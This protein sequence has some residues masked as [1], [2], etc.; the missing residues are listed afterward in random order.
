M[1]EFEDESKGIELGGLINNVTFNGGANSS[2]SFLE[3]AKS[4]GSEINVSG[5]DSH[6]AT[7][8][9]VN[10]NN[11]TFNATNSIL[12]FGAHSSITNSTI[13]LLEES[14]VKFD[15]DTYLTNTLINS[16][17][18]AKLYLT[19]EAI[20]TT[21]LQEITTPG[22]ELGEFHIDAQMAL[23]GVLEIDRINLSQI[24]GASM[25]LVLHLNLNFLNEFYDMPIGTHTYYSENFFS[26]NNND[27]TNFTISLDTDFVTG[28]NYVYKLTAV[29]NTGSGSKKTRLMAT[30]YA[31]VLG[32]PQAIA[33]GQSEY[34][35]T[36]DEN[37]DVWGINADSSQNNGIFQSDMTINGNNKNLIGNIGV[38]GNTI[39]GMSNPNQSTISIKDLNIKSFNNAIILDNESAAE[40]SYLYLDNSTITNNS[41][42]AYVNKDLST[43]IL[44]NNSKILDNTTTDIFNKAD[45]IFG[46]DNTDNVIGK[47]TG[48]GDGTIYFGN[49]SS[50]SDNSLT[51]NNISGNNIVLSYGSLIINSP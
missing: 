16:N 8:A 21:T 24:P 45:L 43:I 38:D 42:G 5:A 4:E 17:P 6:F 34:S 36:A 26:V 22:W 23:N 50:D 39:N 20:A 33:T 3:N 2:I 12:E 41:I 32:L 28:D 44:S 40:K 18:S 7:D 37:I 9:M 48:S 27:F 30:K 13:N 31:S 29:P 46:F 25:V 19:N 47:I 49:S 14:T 10:I 51:V 15:A 11:G 1:V 35:F